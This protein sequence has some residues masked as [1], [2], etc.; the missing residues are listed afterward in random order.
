MCL[1]IYQIDP[2]KSLLVLGLAWQ[3]ALKK[4]K[5]ELELLADINMLLRVN[6][7]IIGGICY[8]INRYAKGNDKYMEE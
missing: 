1:E 8:S 5:V 2:T 4:T 3:E 6:K 7:R